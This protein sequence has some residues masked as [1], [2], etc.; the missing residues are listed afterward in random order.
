M[1]LRSVR[2]WT[3]RGHAVVAVCGF[4]TELVLQPAGSVSMEQG[5]VIL[6]LLH[7][8]Q[9]PVCLESSV[10]TTN[11]PTAMTLQRVATVSNGIQMGAA[12]P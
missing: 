9:V 7:P 2:V 3:E 12:L 8:S 6:K 4:L 5:P 11:A 10:T 1:S